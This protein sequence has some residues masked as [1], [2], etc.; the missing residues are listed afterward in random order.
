M[1]SSLSPPKAVPYFQEPHKTPAFPDINSI[2]FPTV[3][4]DGNPWGFMI[5]SGHH[6]LSLKGISIEGTINPTTPFY[7]CLELNLSPISGI[8]VYQAINFTQ[9][10]SSSV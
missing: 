10:R 7:P 9:Q 1:S 5:I 3:I 4:L 2:I 6:P 8:Q